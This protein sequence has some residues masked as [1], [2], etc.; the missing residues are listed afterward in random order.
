MLPEKTYPFREMLFRRE[1]VLVA[2]TSWLTS[3]QYLLNKMSL[4]RNKKQ[5][6]VAISGQKRCDQSLAGTQWCASSPGNS[7]F[8]KLV[9]AATFQNLTVVNDENCVCPTS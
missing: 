1:L 7:V 2:V 3:Q 4:N 6:Y 8:A 5:G 9:F